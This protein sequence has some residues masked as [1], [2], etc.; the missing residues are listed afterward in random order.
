M[1][2]KGW[3]AAERVRWSQDRGIEEDGSSHGLGGEEVGLARECV[4]RQAWCTRLIPL[5]Q[6]VSDVFAGIKER[7]VETR[8]G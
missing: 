8:V 4:T 7:E 5:R 3:I 1:I 2:S 6:P